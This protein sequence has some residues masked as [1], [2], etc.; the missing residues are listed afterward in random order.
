MHGAVACH[1]PTVQGDCHFVYLFAS[2]MTAVSNI[3]MQLKKNKK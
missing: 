2:R 1:L 3:L